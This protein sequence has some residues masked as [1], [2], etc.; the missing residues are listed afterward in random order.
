M[1]GSAAVGFDILS[2]CRRFT[3]RVCYTVASGLDAVIR[4]GSGGSAEIC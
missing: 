1:A 2:V 3:G 4:V